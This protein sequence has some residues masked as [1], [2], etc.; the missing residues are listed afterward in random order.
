MG[1]EWGETQRARE[2]KRKKRNPKKKINERGRLIKKERKKSQFSLLF[3]VS[4]VGERIGVYFE[5]IK[6]QFSK[7]AFKTY[8][9]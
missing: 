2:R 7:E 9:L 1:I 6:S 8:R 4:R 5:R 3:L